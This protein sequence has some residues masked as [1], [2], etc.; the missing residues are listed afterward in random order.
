MKNITYEKG[1]ISEIEKLIIKSTI[2]SIQL[3]LLKRKDEGMIINEDIIN[4]ILFEI[5]AKIDEVSKEASEEVEIDEG[6]EELDE[7]KIADAIDSENIGK[8]LSQD[9]GARADAE[10]EKEKDER[11][12]LL[13]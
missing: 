1:A 8:D 3:A 4:E 10:W 9:L 2:R 7:E 11:L 13:S 5:E 12:G 6:G